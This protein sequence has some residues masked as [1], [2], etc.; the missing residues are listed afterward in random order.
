MRFREFDFKFKPKK[1]AFSSHRFLGRKVSQSAVEIGDEHI[2]AARE[3]PVP[4]STKEVEKLLVFANYHR[5]FIAEYARIVVPLY[6]VTGKKPFV[7]GIEHQEAFEGLKGALT[8][9]PVLALPV[10]DGE[11]VLDT[12]SSGEV[13]G[14]E[15]SQIQGDQERTIAYGS[16]SLSHEQ[17]RYCATRKEL[18]AVIRFTRIF[19]HYLLGRKLVVKT[20]HHSLVWLM[21]F[22]SPQD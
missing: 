18:L 7:W 4:A 22:R 10:P 5:G 17:R 15:L 13:I 12:D 3:W 6:R 2:E 1:C 21:N 11:F 14:A 16:L 8:S 19:R 20:D 9:P